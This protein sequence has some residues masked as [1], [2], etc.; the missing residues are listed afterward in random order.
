MLAVL[1]VCA[2]LTKWAGFGVVSVFF[3]IC[4]CFVLL[5]LF[6]AIG[7]GAGA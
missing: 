6:V 1:V 7:K 3:Q 2:A 5:A 4:I